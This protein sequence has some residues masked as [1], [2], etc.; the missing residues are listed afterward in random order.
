M[1]VISIIALLLAIIIPTL[2]SVRA[3][4]RLTHCLSN[5]HAQGIVLAQYAAEF[6]DHLPPR[7]VSLTDELGY[8]APRLLDAFLARYSGQP[9][10]KRRLD[11]WRTPTG[12]WRCPDVEEARDYDR[13]SH[14]GVAHYA[15][16]GW[17]FNS[18]TINVVSRQIKEEATVYR[19]WEQA[20]NPY[21]WR[22]VGAVE[23][24]TDLMAL[25]DNVNYYNVEHGHWEAREAIRMSYDTVY[26]PDP[27]R[28]GENEGSHMELAARPTLFL[29]GRA[30]P[31]PTSSDYWL[32][33]QHL[34]H[35][36]GDTT[37]PCAVFFEREVQR[38]MWFLAPGA[39]TDISDD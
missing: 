23:R 16:N 39:F 6:R 2:Q 18:V 31:L 36:G 28:R 3:H 30:E 17:L 13:R 22:E 37:G 33:T 24:P 32:D 26:A 11:G 12:V 15:A 4:G 27:Y 14:S 19:G 20:V 7:K 25:M 34:Y 1:T 5:M 10:G 38:F 35:A 9:F 21:R 29:D 8:Y